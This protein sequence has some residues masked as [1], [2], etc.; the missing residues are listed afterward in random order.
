MHGIFSGS[1]LQLVGPILD[2][3]LAGCCMSFGGSDGAM[4]VHWCTTSSITLVALWYHSRTDDCRQ[5]HSDRR[6]V[7]VDD[8]GGV[9]QLVSSVVF[10]SYKLVTIPAL[11]RA[12]TSPLTVTEMCFALTC[13][14]SQ[15][16]SGHYWLGV[17]GCSNISNTK[18]ST[19]TVAVCRTV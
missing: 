9:C 12:T 5:S 4:Q 2:H 8:V 14:L 19:S 17:V 6:G 10:C 16:V 18:Y 15:F 3:C 13:I 7:F 1:A 11:A